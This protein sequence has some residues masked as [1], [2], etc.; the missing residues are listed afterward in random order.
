MDAIRILV[1]GLCLMSL[2]VTAITVKKKSRHQT[3]AAAMTFVL[4]VLN[5]ILMALDELF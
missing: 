2:V 5:L 4:A 1:T 3:T